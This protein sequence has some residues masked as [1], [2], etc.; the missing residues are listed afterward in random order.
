MQYNFN[1]EF[2]ARAA[3]SNRPRLKQGLA[4]SR[5]CSHPPLQ[6]PTH[7]LRAALLGPTAPPSPPGC[8]GGT[9]LWLVFWAPAPKRD[10]SMACLSSGRLPPK[11][12]GPPPSK[13]SAVCASRPTPDPKQARPNPNP[14][15]NPD[16]KQAQLV[17]P[18]LGTLI[19]AK[20]SGN[21]LYTSA[22]TDRHAA[23]VR[24][25][26]SALTRPAS[27]PQVCHTRLAPQMSRQGPRQVGSATHTGLLL[28]R[29]SL[30]LDS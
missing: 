12:A 3:R 10:C 20:L 15:P 19:H 17:E 24:G 28:T 5:P 29:L 25:V 1:S 16:P 4:R 27:L 22:Y 21:A 23:R 6:R 11:S 13:A 26:L 8:R 18:R 2:M 7:L 14:P 9:A 30:A